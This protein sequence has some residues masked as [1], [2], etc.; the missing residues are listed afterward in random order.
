MRVK[1]RFSSRA[2]VQTTEVARRRIY[3]SED[4]RY[5]VVENR[6]L[7]GRLPTIWHA[8]VRRQE[9]WGWCWDL[10]GRHRTRRAAERH[11]QR[12]AKSEERRGKR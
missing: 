1:V 8:L 2:K 5:R 12:R 3:E 11:I 6:F 9:S 4:G 7:V 10:L